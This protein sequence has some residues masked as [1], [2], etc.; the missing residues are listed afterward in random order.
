MHYSRIKVIHKLQASFPDFQAA[1]RKWGCNTSGSW[2]WR[3]AVDRKTHCV[4]E[5]FLLEVYANLHKRCSSGLAEIPRYTFLKQ[6]AGLT[7]STWASLC[8]PSPRDLPSRRGGNL[9]GFVHHPQ[10][11]APPST[12]QGRLC[13]WLFTECTRQACAQAAALSSQHQYA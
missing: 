2:A 8:H 3:K 12:L 10:L 11:P 6:P 9:S 13:E 4:C 1:L 5:V 7:L